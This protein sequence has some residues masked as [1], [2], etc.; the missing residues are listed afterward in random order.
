ML[1]I[2]AYKRTLAANQKEYLMKCWQHISS[3]LPDWFLTITVNML[4]V[5]LIKHLHPSLCN[6]DF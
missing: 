5:M 2:G 1:L 3:P 6:R 4:G